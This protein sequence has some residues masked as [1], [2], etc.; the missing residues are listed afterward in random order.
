M[1]LARGTLASILRQAA[2]SVDEF[3]ELLCVPG[4][5]G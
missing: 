3:R 1:G 4:N 2:L 5:L